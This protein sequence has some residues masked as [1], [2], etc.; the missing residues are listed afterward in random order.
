MA[1]D[2]EGSRKKTG[3]RGGRFNTA[4]IFNIVCMKKIL[5]KK[6]SVL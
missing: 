6:H 3:T 4:E 2:L 1:R 5:I